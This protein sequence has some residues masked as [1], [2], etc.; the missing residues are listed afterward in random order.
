VWQ[1][2]R[3][4]HDTEPSQ[5]TT[6]QEDDAS[7]LSHTSQPQSERSSSRNDAE[8]NN[9]INTETHSEEDNSFIAANNRDGIP[10]LIGFQDENTEDYTNY[11]NRLRLLFYKNKA[12]YELYIFIQWTVSMCFTIYMILPQDFLNKTWNSMVW[13]VFGFNLVCRIASYTRYSQ[14]LNKEKA[15]HPLA[16][17]THIIVVILMSFRN[18]IFKNAPEIIDANTFIQFLFYSLVVPMQWHFYI[19]VLKSSVEKMNKLLQHKLQVEEVLEKHGILLFAIHEGIY[20]ALDVA[21]NT[22]TPI[23]FAACI[24]QTLVIGAMYLPAWYYI[25]KNLLWYFTESKDSE[26]KRDY[27]GEL[28]TLAWFE[29]AE[30]VLSITFITILT[31]IAKCMYA[32][33]YFNWIFDQDDFFLP[34]NFTEI[35][36]WVIYGSG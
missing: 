9:S 2:P 32:Y 31:P 36:W 19:T 18:P 10:S 23:R 17:A 7:V 5:V 11:R 15:W 12:L 28:R 6:E 22:S 8:N 20:V 29:V 25:A 13:K 34:R 21:A 35:L 30:S 27:N 4:R 33:L 14:I 26:D 24:N 1:V 16:L 3:L